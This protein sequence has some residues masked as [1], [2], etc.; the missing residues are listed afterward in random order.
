MNE[1]ILELKNICVSFPRKEFAVKNVSVSI[2]PNTITSVIGAAGA[3]KTTLLRAINRMHE[4]YPDIKTSGEILLNEKNILTMNPAE[5]RRRIGM[6]FRSPNPFPA[7][8]IYQNVLSGYMLNKIFLS[9]EEKDKVVEE[10]LQEVG[11]W[12]EVKNRLN[13]KASELN[14]GEQQR[15]C[16]ARCLALNPEIMLMDE[17]TYTL[18]GT[19]ANRIEELIYRIKNKMTIIIVTNQL[20]QA[21]SISDYSMYME[22]GELIEFDSCNKLFVNPKDKRT[23]KYI[24]GQTD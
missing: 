2:K 23:E 16:I 20:L 11:L 15:L 3:G 5:V 17:P 22:K 1:Y 21:S 14:L 18:S 24:T 13:K 10:T 19:C 9:K 4:L 7:M 8:D 12:E 6:V